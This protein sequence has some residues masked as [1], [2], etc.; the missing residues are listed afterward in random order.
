MTELVLQLLPYLVGALGL[1]GAV[2][3]LRR[4]GRE[5]ERRRRAEE[6]L[7]RVQK[8]QA[9]GGAAKRSDKSPEDIAR[10]NDGSWR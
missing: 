10:E 1:L 9:A 3:G 8:G 2:F 6:T 4:S 7:D 5:T